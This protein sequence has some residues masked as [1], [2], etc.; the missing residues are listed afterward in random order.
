MLPYFHK[1]HAK[2]LALQM[3]LKSVFKTT[4]KHPLPQSISNASTLILGQI[5]SV[6]LLQVLA[7]RTWLWGGP[8]HASPGEVIR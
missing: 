3:A 4:N 1:A 5:K 2:W 7:G 6:M 8:S